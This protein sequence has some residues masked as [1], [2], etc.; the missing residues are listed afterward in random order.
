MSE[1]S[2]LSSPGGVLLPLPLPTPAL[3]LLLKLGRRRGDLHGRAADGLVTENRSVDLD[4]CHR[5]LKEVTA[6]IRE[7]KERERR[8]RGDPWVP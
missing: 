1:V 7:D 3:A 2:C 8:R 5:F 4:R 6:I